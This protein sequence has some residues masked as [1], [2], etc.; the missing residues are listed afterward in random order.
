MWMRLLIGLLEQPLPP[1]APDDF[2]AAEAW[3]PWKVKKRVAQIV[4]RL[5]QRYGDPKRKRD[6]PGAK[7]ALAFAQHFH[8]DWMTVC[9]RSCL[10]VLSL[11]ANGTA[12]P[13]RVVT[14]CLNYL[15]EGVRYKRAWSDLKPQLAPLFLG[16]LF[17]LLCFSERDQKQWDE[18][19]VEYVRKEFDVIEDFYN[20]L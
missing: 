14:L 17:P 19:P 3:R 18:D 15:E 20:P 7:E 4:H 6:G 5:L 1:G 2:E 11:R 16:V 8:D 10:G 9:Q 13:D 12:C